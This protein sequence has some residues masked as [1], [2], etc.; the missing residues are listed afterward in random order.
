MKLRAIYHMRGE[1]VVF[2]VQIYVFGRRAVCLNRFKEIGV[3][4]WLRTKI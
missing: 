3:T 4:A 1:T 2:P